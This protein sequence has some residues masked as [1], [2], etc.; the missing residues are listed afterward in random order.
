[1]KIT[2]SDVDHAARLARLRF[3]D[4]QLELYTGQLNDILA[5]FDKLQQLDTTG[6]EPSSH[7]VNLCN[8]FRED[9]IKKS[10]VDTEAIKN[11]PESERGLFKV[12]RVIEG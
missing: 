11:A 10:I 5:Y 3:S 2:R 7:A 1:M 4:E 12:P 6:V 9:K 8:A